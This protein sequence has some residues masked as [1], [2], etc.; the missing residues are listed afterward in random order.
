SGRPDARS[1]IETLLA[2]HLFTIR[3]QAEGDWYRY[4]HL[5]AAFLRRRLAAREP[6]RVPGLHRRAGRGWLAAGGPAE[7][8]RHLVEGGGRTAAAHR[9]RPALR[10][11][12]AP[13]NAHAPGGPA[14]ARAR[15][16]LRLPLRRGRDRAASRRRAPRRCRDAHPARVL[17]GRARVLD[18]L[19]TGAMR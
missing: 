12:P 1:L 4:H 7:A 10:A 13:R 3:L 16:R 9:G 15:V 2:G 6:G 11:P 19:P 17:G 18:R 14:H 5:F 8:V